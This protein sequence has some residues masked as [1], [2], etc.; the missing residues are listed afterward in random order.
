MTIYS[1]NE[2]RMTFITLEDN[3]YEL[4][5]RLEILSWLV[6]GVGLSRSDHAPNPFLL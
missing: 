5:E 2:R 3:C 6:S 1:S 4:K